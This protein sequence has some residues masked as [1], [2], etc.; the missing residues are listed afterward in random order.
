MTTD[1]G[2]AAAAPSP[3]Q[4]SPV[5]Q[6][7]APPVPVPP[8]EPPYYAVIFTSLRMSDG[9]GYG[10]TAERME[11]LVRKTPGFLGMDSA[12]TPGGLGITVGYFESEDAI[13]EWRSQ[14][15]HRAAR[16]RGR[17]Q[18]YENFSVHVSKVERSYSFVREQQRERE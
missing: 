18:W 1:S 6:P 3:V 12:R 14:V 15:E 2:A 17:A 11:E 10:E 13:R 7:P 5:P 9:A 8:F 4:P 16:E